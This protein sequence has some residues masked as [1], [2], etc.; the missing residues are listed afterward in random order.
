MSSA[1][2][3][4]EKSTPQ[5]ITPL[6]KSETST[7]K[8]Q[9][10]RQFHSSNKSSCSVR[11]TD[12][13]SSSSCKLTLSEKYPGEQVIGSREE[14]VDAKKRRNTFSKLDEVVSTLPTHINQMDV[15]LTRILPVDD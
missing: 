5:I 2:V 8:T 11:Q 14:T 13:S 9:F 6:A 15:Q 3:E 7:H 1:T 12:V 4:I 10:Q